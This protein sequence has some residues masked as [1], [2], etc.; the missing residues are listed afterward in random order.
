MNVLLTSVA[1]IFFF[2]SLFISS[3]VKGSQ[4]DLKEGN[5]VEF[6]YS[7]K[8]GTNWGLQFQV[9]EGYMAIKV[10]YL[11]KYEKF[12]SLIDARTRRYNI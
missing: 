11:L 5:D 9:V 10:L 2:F 12:N 8:Q 6:V 7:L 4:I 1:Q 3:F